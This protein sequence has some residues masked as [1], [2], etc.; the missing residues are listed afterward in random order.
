ME[1]T[2]LRIFQAV[3]EERSITRAAERLGYVQSN[4]T[5]RIRQLENELGTKLFYRQSRGMS[6]TAAGE[7]L[8][9]YT[10]KILQLFEDAK[11][12]TSDSGQ[13]SG[14]FKLGSS[15]TA[16]SIYVPQILVD[17]HKTYPNV[18]L[19]L[20]TGYS[21]DLVQKVLQ[22]ELD[23]AFVNAPVVHP[24]IIEE[25]TFQEEVVLV[26]AISE[27]DPSSFYRKPI[28]MNSSS[29]ADCLLKT[30][31]EG[32]IKTQGIVAP[33]IMQFHGMEAIIAG[34]I[35]DLGFSLVPKSSVQKFYEAR[36]INIF[37]VPESFSVVK[38]SFIRHK[39]ALMTSTLK[40]FLKMLE[41]NRFKFVAS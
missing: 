2:D 3:S 1:S 7:T 14:T 4:I 12:A 41:S 26:T 31:I 18:D 34:V 37:P 35:A 25:I 39:D 6:L 17:Y 32:W 19:S 30:H 13:P 16:A 20:F 33:R 9:L 15:H 36:M 5:T 24:D 29:N 23:G 22:F 28:L 10:N 27:T 40:K 21:K 11:K 38:T 8:L